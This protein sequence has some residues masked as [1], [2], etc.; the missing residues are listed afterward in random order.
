MASPEA[1][2]L[3]AECFTD[4]VDEESLTRKERSQRPSK[5]RRTVRREKF[6]YL[7]GIGVEPQ[8]KPFDLYGLMWGRLYDAIDCLG[9]WLSTLGL[10]T[11]KIM[12]QTVRKKALGIAPSSIPSMT[13]CISPPSLALH[14]IVT[15]AHPRAPPT[16]VYLKPQSPSP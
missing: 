1:G 6:R 4:V 10:W 9:L 11:S 15:A 13:C 2:L 5:S 3:G 16:A 7:M 8:E 12:A 14:A